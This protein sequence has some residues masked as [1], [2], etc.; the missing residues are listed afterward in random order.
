MPATRAALY[1]IKPTYGIVSSVGVMPISTFAD[2]VGPMAKSPRDLADLLDVMVDH[3][4]TE[5]PSGGYKSCLKDSFE[6]IAIGALDPSTWKFPPRVTTPNES[7]TNQMVSS[8]MFCKN[9]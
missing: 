6:H 3:A 9:I 2:T 5:I 8:N 4:L 1:T 7:A